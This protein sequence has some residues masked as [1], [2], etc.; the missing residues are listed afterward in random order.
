MVPSGASTG[1]FEAVELRDGKKGYY[2]GL[3]VE[4]CS[5]KCQYKTG[6]GSCRGKCTWIRIDIDEILIRTDG[7][8]NKSSVGANATLGV[9]MAVARAACDGTEDSALSVSGRL[10]CKQTAGTYDEYSEWGKACR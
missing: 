10:S 9:S 3:S 8:D 7:T 5:G 2:T 1:K 6:R 4:K